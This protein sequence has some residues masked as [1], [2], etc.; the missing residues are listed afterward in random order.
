MSSYISLGNQYARYAIT[1]NISPEMSP[2][3]MHGSIAHMAIEPDAFPEL[4]SPNF[5]TIYPVRE[6]QLCL[7]FFVGM[8][9]AGEPQNVGYMTLPLGESA[10]NE[11]TGY[12][13]AGEQNG[14]LSEL[15]ADHLQVLTEALQ[16]ALSDCK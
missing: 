16:T 3:S 1:H 8:G 14:H 5:V 4:G 12:R 6:G 2:G 9:G 11:V 13:L 7:N 15:T 10:A